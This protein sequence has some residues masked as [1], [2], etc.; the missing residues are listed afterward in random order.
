[1]QYRDEF[2]VR[3]KHIVKGFDLQFQVRQHGRFFSHAHPVVVKSDQLSDKVV[4]KNLSRLS[5]QEFDPT[6]GLGEEF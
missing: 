3:Q 2:G 6:F 4:F 5:G 1:M